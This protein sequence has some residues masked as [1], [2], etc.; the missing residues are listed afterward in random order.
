[1]RMKT[2]VPV[3]W[4]ASLVLGACAPGGREAG[5]G[6]VPE[7]VLFLRTPR[8]LALVK[9]EQDPVAVHF[10]DAVP[11]MD[12]SAV[13]QA[14]P[15][16]K[17]TYVEAFDTSSGDQLWS[18]PIDGRFEVRAVA[19]DGSVAALGLPRE[20]SGY[21]IGRPSTT[22]VMVAANQAK[23]RTITLEGNFEPEAF[24]TDGGS[25]FV[26][27]YLPPRNPTSYQVRR[28]D[29][30]T[31]KVGGVYTV[32]AELQE[33]MQGTARIQTASPDGRR[34]YTL[35]SLE[36]A[37]GS[38]HS[39]VHVLDLEEEWAHCVDLPPSFR[40]ANEKAV[41]LS[42]APDGKRLYVADALSGSLAEI[43]TQALE[44]TRTSE[45]A[46]GPWG[47]DP[48]HAAR[49]ADGMLYV[50]SGTGLLSVD[51]ATFAPGRSW[52]MDEEIMGIQAGGDGR[53]LYVGLRD[54]IAVIDT[55]TGR[56]LEA[57]TPD[58]I[59]SIDQ[60]GQST[61]ELNEVRREITCAC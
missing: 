18:R 27:E 21:A 52:D 29:L 9:A 57:L 19:E 1:M 28:L 24:S 11:S 56:N 23:P 36:Y 53:R 61:R 50:G 25:L 20:S 45:V 48:A 37:D 59:D 31:G 8:G 39:F 49:G 14:V 35:Y 7:D 42:V 10:S 60:L 22:F 40:L 54:R 51:A 30:A 17:N 33:A 4:I 32:D 58:R 55:V 47:R 34:L 41:A 6:R 26:I 13:V 15:D 38:L 43:D 16:G 12:W 3:A 2:L 5:S 44:V 46:L